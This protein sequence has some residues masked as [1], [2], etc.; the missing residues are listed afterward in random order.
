[1]RI[2]RKTGIL[3]SSATVAAMTLGTAGAAAAVTTAPPAQPLAKAPA[4]DPTVVLNQLSRFG[5]VSK[6]VE[7]LQAAMAD[8]RNPARV[9]RLVSQAK[10]QLDEIAATAK[11]T[12][13]GRTPKPGKAATHGASGQPA[14]S[15]SS[16][17]ALIT[18]AVNQLEAQLN[19]VVRAVDAN[20]P[21]S[22]LDAVDAALRS[23]VNV[24][25]AVLTASGLPPVSLPSL[26]Q[27]PGPPSTATVKP[28]APG[29]TT[30]PAKPSPPSA[31]N[32]K[33]TGPGV[34]A[35]N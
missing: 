2:S 14:G 5:A 24:V 28:A 23:T 6:V 22:I 35:H 3:I 33:P 20:D 32:V 7:S 27:T 29:T 4:P 13:P 12:G 1:M 21:T 9:S 8:K 25:N 30:A 17:D 11:T 26:A 18:K 34:A 19:S 10:R 15:A 16:A 31:P